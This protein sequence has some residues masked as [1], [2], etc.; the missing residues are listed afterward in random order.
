MTTT[1]TP[2]PTVRG[3]FECAVPRVIRARAD[4]LFRAWTDPEKARPWLTNG[5]DL[6]LQP[7]V[8]GLF[9][10]DMVYNGHT[11]P[12]YGRY[13]QV[14]TDTLLEFTW[15]SQGT[16]GKESLVRVAF[17]PQG[18]STKLTITH[19]GLPDEKNRADHEGGW[20]EILGWLEERLGS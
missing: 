8:G 3:P 4:R 5:G 10:L 18:E 2:N 16:L 13:L 11:Y 9:F 17:E 19:S 7:H 20:T 6:I 14:V 15:M 1:A 12:H